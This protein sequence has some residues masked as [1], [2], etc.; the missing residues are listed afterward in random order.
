VKVKVIRP[1]WSPNCSGVFNSFA[2]V[3]II[4]ATCHKKNI[5]YF[6]TVFICSWWFSKQIASISLNN[7]NLLLLQMKMGYFPCSRSRWP[8]YLRCGFAAVRLLGFRVRIPPRHGRLTL[9]SVLSCQVEVS[10][11]SWSLVQRSPTVC[12]VSECDREASIHRRR[13]TDNSCNQQKCQSFSAY[14]IGTKSIRQVLHQSLF[15]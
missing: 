2:P 5:L 14:F 12:G 4:F 3:L 15:R 1:T 6:A 13:N 9:V 11:T 7:G 8:R 10:E